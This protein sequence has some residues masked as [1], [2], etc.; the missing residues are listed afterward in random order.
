MKNGI[1]V[2]IVLFIVIAVLSIILMF[3]IGRKA[4]ERYLSVANFEEC[5]KAGYPIMESYPSRCSTPDGKTYTQN[6]STST[7]T[8]ATSTKS[9]NVRMAT[10]RPEELVKSPL[11]I[12]GSARG[13]WFFEASFPVQLVDANGTLIAQGP[14]TAKGEWMTTDFVPFE[15]SLVFTNPT[16][17]TGTLILKKD[18][19]SGDLARDEEHRIPITFSK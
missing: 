10:P 16:T 8:I 14:A 5:A 18:N 12:A 4:P 19:P 2:I 11:K 3:D 9:S 6:V 13:T 7:I 15:A 1:L 17:A